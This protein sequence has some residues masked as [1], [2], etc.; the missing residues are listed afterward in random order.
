M[1]RPW[2]FALAACLVLALPALGPAAAQDALPRIRPAGPIE[3]APDVEPYCRVV[4]QATL[5]AGG[6]DAFAGQESSAPSAQLKQWFGSRPQRGFDDPGVNMAFGHTFTGL[7]GRILGATLTVHLRDQAGSDATNDALHLQ[8]NGVRFSW[9]GYLSSLAAASGSAYPGDAT[10]V[11]DLGAL[12]VPAGAGDPDL[13]DDMASTG[14]LDVYVQDDADVD[15]LQL[16][17]EHCRCEGARSVLVEE[18]TRDDF[19]G[20]E[21]TNPRAALEAWTPGASRDYDQ[22]G[23]DRHF[24][25]TLRLP[26]SACLAGAILRLRV[27]PQEGAPENDWL[28]VQ[29]DDLTGR[30]AHGQPLGG[31]LVVGTGEVESLPEEFHGVVKR[32]RQIAVTPLDPVV[33]RVFGSKTP[34]DLHASTGPRVVTV[35]LG[36]LGLLSTIEAAGYVDVY[37]QDDHDV[38]HASLTL[39]YA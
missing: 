20:A 14:R 34:V 11:L 5:L 13:L 24:A 10:I 22:T 2:S 31:G 8:F 28:W 19:V 35:D 25:T 27:S 23:S 7:P 33:D 17:V 26:D 3:N 1:T 9:G 39:T 30:F 12:P 15:Y 18:G 32:L 38:D 36:A 6:V 4:A 29:L 37:V 21:A 16:D